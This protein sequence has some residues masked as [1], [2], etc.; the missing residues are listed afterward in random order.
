MATASDGNDCQAF[1]AASYRIDQ[2]AV[3]FIV[4]A[5]P[6]H[7]TLADCTSGWVLSLL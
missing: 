6:Q 2:Y 1:A 3:R 5:L 4:A 7:L